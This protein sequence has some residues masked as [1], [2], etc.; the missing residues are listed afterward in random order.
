[1]ARATDDDGGS[2]CRTD[3][4]PTISTARPA[5]SGASTLRLG[6][7]LEIVEDGSVIA[8]WPY[9]TIRRADGP[10]GMLR[11]SSTAALPLARIE[12]EDPATIEALTARCTSLDVGSRRH[13]ADLRIVFWSLAAVCS[14]VAVVMFGIPYAADRLAPLVPPR[15]SDGMGEAVDGQVG[16]I[17]G[18]KV[19]SEPAGRAAFTR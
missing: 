13:Q 6:D 5:A 4:G 15:S 10:P 2:P 1:M 8:T 11:L 18:S 14:I 16:L 7:A 12:T 9:D 19:C 17:F 3:A